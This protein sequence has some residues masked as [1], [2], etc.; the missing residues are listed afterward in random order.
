[1]PYTWQNSK[2][3]SSKFRIWQGSQYAS[4]TQHPEYARIFFDRVSN[5]SWVLN[6]PGF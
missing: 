6:M 5:V 2:Y 4:V 3:G 1:M